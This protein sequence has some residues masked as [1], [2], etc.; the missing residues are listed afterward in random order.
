MCARTHTLTQNDG[1]K[2]KRSKQ[3]KWFFLQSLVL[4]QTWFL[5]IFSEL[6]I[7]QLKIGTCNGQALSCAVYL[8]LLPQFVLYT[9]IFSAVIQNNLRTIILLRMRKLFFLQYVVTGWYTSSNKLHPVCVWVSV[10]SVSAHETTP[11]SLL[12]SLILHSQHHQA[13]T[14]RTYVYILYQS[15]SVICIGIM[16]AIHA[17]LYMIF[18]RILTRTQQ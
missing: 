12:H 6:V 3:K 4:M 1:G 11:I 14:C 7:C 15:I 8:L 9:I 10:L 13:I 2:K 17:F 18:H 5:L 16:H